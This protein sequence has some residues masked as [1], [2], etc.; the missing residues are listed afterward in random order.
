ML[1][2]LLADDHG[3]VRQ[4]LRRI[5][6]EQ[7]GWVV[8]AELSDGREAVSQAVA[9][10]PDVVILDV[11]MPCLSGI[12]AARQIAK[13]APTVHI[14]MLSMHV[15]EQHITQAVQAGACGYLLK[16][17]A[18][19]D[20]VAAVSATAQGKPFFSP[21]AERVMRDDYRRSMTKRGVVDRYETLSDREREIFQ[22]IAEGNS[23]KAIAAQLSIGPTTVETHRS[24]I[25][26]KLDIHSVAEIVICAVR[27]GIVS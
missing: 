3:L 27:R 11:G 1:S 13:R 21:A 23:N 2:I 18:D 15:D 5:L 19:N 16:D 14:L 12:E 22:L 6:E 26:Q 10:Q 9:L 24:H 20:L 7:P 17:S 25:L 4:G 8:V